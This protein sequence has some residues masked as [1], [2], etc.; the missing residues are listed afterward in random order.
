MTKGQWLIRRVKVTSEGLIKEEVGANR[1][2]REQI[3]A[4]NSCKRVKVGAV[5]NYGAITP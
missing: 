3:L 5:L 1:K 2:T 4:F